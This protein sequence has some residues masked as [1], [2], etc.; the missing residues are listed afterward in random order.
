VKQFTHGAAEPA[1]GAISL[2]SGACG[3]RKRGENAGSFPSVPGRI[4]SE[5]IRGNYPEEYR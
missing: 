2:P 1:D 5:Q 4:M 3:C